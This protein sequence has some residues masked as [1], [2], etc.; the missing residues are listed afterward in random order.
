MAFAVGNRKDFGEVVDTDAGANSPERDGG[1]AKP[2][3]AA[4]A[5]VHISKTKAQSLVDELL[6]RFFSGPPQPFQNDGDIIVDGYS[7]SHTSRHTD[8]MR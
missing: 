8:L 7:R 3:A 2:F 4:G 5:I 1:R 6:K